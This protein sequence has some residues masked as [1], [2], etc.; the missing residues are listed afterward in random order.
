[1]IRVFL[2]SGWLLPLWLFTDLTLHM[3]AGF[4]KTRGDS[5][6]F[7]VYAEYMLHISFIWSGLALIYLIKNNLK[8]NH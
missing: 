4:G 6:P 7:F 5:F 8:Q 2:L 1:M 3:I